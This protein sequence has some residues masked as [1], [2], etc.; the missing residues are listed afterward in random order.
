E[1]ATRHALARAAAVEIDLI[2]SGV[3]PSARRR[4]ELSGI[5][6]SQLQRERML[7]RIESEQPRAI[8]AHDRRGGG[9]LGVKQHVSQEAAQEEAAMAVGPVHHRR[10]AYRMRYQLIGSIGH[11]VTKCL[12]DCRTGRANLVQF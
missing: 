8:T 5:T 1:S 2:I 9:P 10:H 12:P 3:L 7:L 11:S 4:G 6:A